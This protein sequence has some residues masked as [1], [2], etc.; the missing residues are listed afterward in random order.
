[1]RSNSKFVRIVSY[2]VLALC[3]VWLVVSGA[4][5]LLKSGSV[6]LDEA[7]PGD[8]CEFSADYADIAFEVTHFSSFIPTGKDQFYLMFAGDD[9]VPLLVRAKP[10][11][12]NKRFD[13]DGDSFD[14][15]VTV[16][17]TVVRMSTKL[18]YEVISMN[19]EAGGDYLN[20]NF[21]ID[22]RYKEFGLMRII[23][24]I[25]AAVLLVVFFLGRRSGVIGG[26]KALTAIFAVL[27]LAF[28]LFVSYALGVGGTGS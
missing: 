1:M 6:P 8:V 15:A 23:S 5:N 4:V 19:N 22:T 3:W 14:N 13:A 9:L 11:W 21:Y 20:G 10:S 25:G 27:A 2:V 26:N 28:A 16:K 18:S 7:A 17:G 12:I 24:A